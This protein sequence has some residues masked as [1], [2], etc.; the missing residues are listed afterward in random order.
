MQ[1]NKVSKTYKTGN[2]QVEALKEINL[3]IGQHEF[4]AVMGASGSGKSTLLNIIGL[5]DRATK[6]SY[7]LE[8]KDV[9]N[10][11]DDR[12]AILRNEFMGFVFQSFFLLPRFNALQNVMLPL[13]YSKKYSWQD[14]QRGESLLEK[15]GIANFAHHKPSQLSGGQQQRVAI[16]RALVCEPNIIFAD[17]P[18][19]ALDSKTG[20][21]ILQ[22]FKKIHTNERKTVVIVTH[23]LKIAKHC[24]RIIKIHDGKIVSDEKL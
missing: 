10:L 24:K 3:S 8:G 12:W 1:L 21:E 4:V 13:L 6:G 23:D 11:S 7:I 17:E 14:K 5:L 20:E 19:G 2:I 9:E 22:L 18:T 15:M 16:A